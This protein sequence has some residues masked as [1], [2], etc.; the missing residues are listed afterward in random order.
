MNRKCFSQL[1]AQTLNRF[2]LF[3]R[4]FV[5]VLFT[6]FYKQLSTYRLKRVHLNSLNK[7][8]RPCDHKLKFN[9]TSQTAY[10]AQK[11]HFFLDIQPKCNYE[12]REPKYYYENE[13]KVVQ[14]AMPTQCA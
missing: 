14:S 1:Q 2:C 4:W 8:F 13:K 12:N 3:V 9:K 7:Q 5:I 11:F 10:T 6:L